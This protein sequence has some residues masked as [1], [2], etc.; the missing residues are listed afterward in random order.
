MADGPLS[1]K[2]AL[3]TGGSRRIGREIALR[4]A[5]DGAAV[6]VNARSSRAEAEAVVAEIEA[7]GGRAVAA[8]G[9]ITD[10][11][12]SA[13]V[14]DTVVK[15]FGRLDILVH[16]AVSREHGTIETLELDEWRKALSVVLDGAFLSVK[17][18]APHLQKQGGA[19]V[20]IGGA[21]AFLGS[22]GPATPTAKSGLVGLTRSLAGVMGPK[23]VTV[24]LLSP[25]RIE[26]DDD[27]AARRAHLGGSRPVDK[28]PMARVGTPADV[29]GAVAVLVGPD[30]RYVTGQTI[31][32]AGGLVM[33]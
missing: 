28:I 13:V 31:H 27:P 1:G 12:Q 16:N 8:M 24:N 11:A 29:A 32:L 21:S 15:A 22:S 7:A 23:D 3:I 26:A 25:G 2:A 30:F 20:F 10:Q 9:D 4:L 17:H 19:I 6:A 5:R 18:A 33:G 14:V